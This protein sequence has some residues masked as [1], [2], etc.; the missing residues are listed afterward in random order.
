MNTNTEVKRGRGRPAT[1]P[2]QDTKMAGYNLPITTLE[3]VAT[4]AA[5]REWNQNALVNRALLSFLNR[6][7]GKGKS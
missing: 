2:D 1:F 6:G 5:R 3:A 7:K 4:E